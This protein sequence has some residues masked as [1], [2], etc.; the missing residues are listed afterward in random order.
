[1]NF[2]CAGFAFGL[3]FAS[4]LSASVSVDSP[5]VSMVSDD[6]KH[7]FNIDTSVFK[8]DYLCPFGCLWSE[9]N[10]CLYFY[11]YEPVDFWSDFSKSLTEKQSLESLVSVYSSSV[12][13]VKKP[14]T[15]DISSVSLSSST[16][17]DSSGNGF[18]EDFGSYGLSCLSAHY[19]SDGY[20]RKYRVELF[21]GFDKDG[22]NRWF[23]GAVNYHY[24]YDYIF[25]NDLNA[26]EVKNDVYGAVDV[27]SETQFDGSTGK[28]VG[29][30]DHIINIERKKVAYLEK[31]VRY[32]MSFSSAYGLGETG[33]CDVL[34]SYY[35]AF[36][37][38]VSLDDIRKVQLVYKKRVS[39]GRL[40][41]STDSG[42]WVDSKD[43]DG[44]VR[45]VFNKINGLGVVASIKPIG[46]S[47]GFFSDPCIIDVEA[48]T[49]SYSSH[50]YG[51]FFHFWDHSYSYS[52]ISKPSSDSLTSWSSDVQS[53]QWCFRFFNS[54]FC[55]SSLNLPV[56]GTYHWFPS[57]DSSDID[58]GSLGGLPVDSTA[59]F[60]DVSDV[61]ILRLWDKKK[62]G[63]VEY[64]T[65]DKPSDSSG[66]DPESNDNPI[67]LE[68]WWSQFKAW[69][70]GNLPSSV[71]ICLAVLVGLPLFLTLIIQNFPAFIRLLAFIVKWVFKILIFPIKLIVSL[72]S[73]SK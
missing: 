17:L 22:L 55:L 12:C 68:D 20:F 63:V 18:V 53:Y 72:F 51:D 47:I 70:V 2:I 42:S 7:N 15:I 71:F 32:N 69:F 38:D 56:S 58:V 28:L 4:S 14:F 54:V 26:N 31:V 40:I 45:W 25:G 23:V 52:K 29:D 49:V 59:G 64:W 46:S 44:L 1:M 3:V 62:T 10:D 60:V 66:L 61:Q 21:N 39:R 73:K 27:A 9:R 36:D 43:S 16:E 34:Q 33:S 8:S 48:G 5:V 37:S 30:Y 41:F 67:V 11:L 35:C 6:L 24:S 13:L 65:V 50:V 57:I 19:T